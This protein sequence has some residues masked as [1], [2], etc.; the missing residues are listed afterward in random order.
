MQELIIY[1]PVTIPPPTPS[2]SLSLPSKSY[3][4]KNPVS[5]CIVSFKPCDNF[6]SYQKY[7]SNSNLVPR[8]DLAPVYLTHLVFGPVLFSSTIC[9][10]HTNTFCLVIVFFFL[11]ISFLK[12]FCR[13]LKTVKFQEKGSSQRSL[14]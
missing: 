6:P 3:L 8:H 11:S 9:S 5:L 10:N 14:L 12:S 2:S 13:R 7:H 4:L 1:F